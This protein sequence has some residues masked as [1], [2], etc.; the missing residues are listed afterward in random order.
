LISVAG[1]GYRGVKLKNSG[2]I[3][4]NKNNEMTEEKPFAITMLSA[5]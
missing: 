1:P 2:N 3:Q 5:N 4:A